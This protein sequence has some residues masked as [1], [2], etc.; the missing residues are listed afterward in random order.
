MLKYKKLWLLVV[1]VAFADIA[2]TWYGINAGLS[3][4]NPVVAEA[5]QN[6]GVIGALLGMKF[7]ALGLV[8]VG[9]MMTPRGTW[10]PPALLSVIW[11]SAVLV[12]ISLL[13]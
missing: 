1:L 12:N 13:W 7:I 4:G 2:T 8:F 9:A 6:V 10:L 5:I 3:E 11:F